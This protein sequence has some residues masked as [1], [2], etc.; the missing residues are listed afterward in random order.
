[1]EW[2]GFGDGYVWKGK[3]RGNGLRLRSVSAWDRGLHCGPE[4][5]PI[6]HTTSER[7]FNCLFPSLS[8]AAGGK[9]KSEIDLVTECKVK[10]HIVA[11]MVGELS[12]KKSHRAISKTWQRSVA[13]SL[14]LTEPLPQV[15]V[16]ISSDQLPTTPSCSMSK[17]HVFNVNTTQSIRAENIISVALSPV[18]FSKKKTPLCLMQHR[19]EISVY[20]L[21]LEVCLFKG[22]HARW[23][24]LPVTV[25]GNNRTGNLK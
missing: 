5:F 10:A 17:L 12:L 16:S 23:R 20:S 3:G 15:S 24:N 1:M 8:A 9:G 18:R 13:P 14:F 4:L 6:P 21:R 25:R 7:K 19:A 11:C 22:V 2:R